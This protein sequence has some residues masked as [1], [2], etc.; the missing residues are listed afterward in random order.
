MKNLAFET[1]KQTI[2][3]YVTDK[4]ALQRL[5]KDSDDFGNYPLHEI[6]IP[7]QQF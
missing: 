2:E 4:V 6:C 1:V 7:N 3:Y 5:G